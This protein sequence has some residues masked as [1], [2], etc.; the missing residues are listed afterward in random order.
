MKIMIEINDKVVDVIKSVFTKRNAV[1]AIVVLF[2]IGGVFVFSQ[3]I[4]KPNT[5]STGEVISATEM[6]ENFDTLYTKV[7]Q[8]DETIETLEVNPWEKNGENISFDSG[9]VGIGTHAPET[10][11]H[12]NGMIST[13]GADHGIRWKLFSDV[14]GS[15]T[16]TIPHELDASKIISVQISVV[17]NITGNYYQGSYS[18]FLITIWDATNIMIT[19]GSS[20]YNNQPYRCIVFYV[21]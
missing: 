8:I 15:G 11:L 17:N 2:F 19:H 20:S 21:E 1:A 14:T 18:N 9:N 12:V 3:A 6:N 4:T 7:N 5:F 13:D 16:T 10:Q